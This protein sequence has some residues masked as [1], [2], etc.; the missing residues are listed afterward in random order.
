MVTDPN[1]EGM[2]TIIRWS[3]NAWKSGGIEWVGFMRDEGNGRPLGK[4][5]VMQV[6]LK[7][8]QMA[9]TVHWQVI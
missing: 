7:R 8:L 2:K 5:F 9:M 6:D 4:T 1:C 3:D